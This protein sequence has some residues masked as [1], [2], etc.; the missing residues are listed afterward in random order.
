MDLCVDAFDDEL[1]DNDET[2][3]VSGGACAQYVQITDFSRASGRP[4]CSSH[5]LWFWLDALLPVF[6]EVCDVRL[7]GKRMIVIK[8]RKDPD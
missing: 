6:E 8:I 1:F 2:N 5:L 4:S 3:F 7:P